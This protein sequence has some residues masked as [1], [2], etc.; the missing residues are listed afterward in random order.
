MQTLVG[1]W[2]IPFNF[3][4]QV[5]I[6]L[7]F[8]TLVSKYSD[9]YDLTAFSFEILHNGVIDPLYGLVFLLL[10]ALDVG[11]FQAQPFKDYVSDSEG[12]RPWLSC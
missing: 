2:L 12:N 11:V 3:L 7:P 1:F 5:V 8:K 10:Y 9:I 6:T 4:V